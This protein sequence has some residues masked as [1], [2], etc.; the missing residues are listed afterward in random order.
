MDCLQAI[1]LSWYAFLEEKLWPSWFSKKMNCHSENGP[2]HQTHFLL[3][4][5]CPKFEC[6]VLTVKVMSV[7]WPGP[8]IDIQSHIIND[9]VNYFWFHQAVIIISLI[10][11]VVLLE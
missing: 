2:Y 4:E 1:S 6:T 8:F 7:T 10:G 9:W 3:I 5:N 11:Y